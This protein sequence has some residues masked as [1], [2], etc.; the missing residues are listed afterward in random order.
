MNLLNPRVE[1]NVVW[2]MTAWHEGTGKDI[3]V[4]YHL[5]K[6]ATERYQREVDKASAVGDRVYGGVYR[7]IVR[8]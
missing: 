5:E 8:W 1:P 7:R 2:V 4:V 3:V 6:D